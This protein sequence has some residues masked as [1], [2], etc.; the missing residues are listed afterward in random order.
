MRRSHVPAG[1][2]PHPLGWHQFSQASGRPAP[3]KK[4]KKTYP[5]TNWCSEIVTSSAEKAS[6]FQ[7]RCLLT[8]DICAIYFQK[9]TRAIDS[10]GGQG[11]LEYRISGFI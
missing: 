1:S 10:V 9:C 3:V 2:T 5:G 4:K 6:I 8:I 7:E 11:A